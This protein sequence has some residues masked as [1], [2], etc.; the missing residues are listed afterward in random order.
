MNESKSQV[1]SSPHIFRAAVP[2]FILQSCPPLLDQENV[3]L[4]AARDGDVNAI[5]ALDPN[6]TDAAATDDKGRTA[7][8]LA[9]FHGH[10]AAIDRFARRARSA[11]SSFC[12]GNLRQ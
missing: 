1:A 7:L 11:K 10:A 4:N 5:A 9:S 6:A 12:F 8:I 2:V 3:L